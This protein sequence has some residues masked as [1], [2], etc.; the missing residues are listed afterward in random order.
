MEHFVSFLLLLSWIGWSSAAGNEEPVSYGLDVSF[1]I[2]RRVSTN[3]PWLPHN[4]DP[5]LRVPLEFQD[6]PL[7]VLGNRM[8]MY[9]Q[10]LKACRRAYPQNPQECDN[11]EYTRITMNRRQPQSMRNYTETGFLKIRAPDRV[12]ELIQAF[13]EKNKDKRKEENWG[14][15]NSYINSW[16]APTYLVSVDDKGLRGSGAEL[17]EQIWAAASAVIEEWVAEEIQPVSMYGVRVYTS[18]AV[19]LPHV[20]RLP[21]VASAII[22]VHQDLDEDWPTEVYDHSGRAHNVTLQ[23]GDMLLFESHSVV[24]GHP[25]PLKGRSYASLFIHFEPTGHSYHHNETGFFLRHQDDGPTRH[26]I[27][28]QYRESLENSIGGQSN[29]ASKLPPYIFPASPEEEN[30]RT[31][32]P[33][34]WQ[35]VRMHNSVKV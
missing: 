13:W 14:V 22:N 9:V 7:Q 2:Q 3:Y 19:M 27:D 8:D 26:D 5:S 21:L 6:K 32:H 12:V 10:H 35:P 16:E 17:K 23:P 15:G 33:D 31:F 1:P 11:Y 28:R 24:H 4:L 29:T 34:G 25:F 20:D 18:G 30:W